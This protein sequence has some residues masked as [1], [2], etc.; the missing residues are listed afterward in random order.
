M[1]S[2][3]RKSTIRGPESTSTMSLFRRRPNSL[4]RCYKVSKPSACYTSLA[5]CLQVSRAVSS[6]RYGAAIKSLNTYPICSR[7]TLSNSRITET[8]RTPGTSLAQLCAS[9]WAKI[10]SRRAKMSACTWSSSTMQSRLRTCIGRLAWARMLRRRAEI[11]CL[12]A[13]KLKVQG[14]AGSTS[15]T[16]S[17]SPTT[18]SVLSNRAKAIIKRALKEETTRSLPT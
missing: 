18:A 4:L 7:W 11:V 3:R 10:S 12:W 16:R 5:A 13:C 8:Y 17:I 2:T 6:T 9:S 1:T 15:N 14:K